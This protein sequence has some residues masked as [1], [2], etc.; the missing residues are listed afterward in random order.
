M[1]K[2]V[3]PEDFLSGPGQAVPAAGAAAVVPL[4]VGRVLASAVQSL[5]GA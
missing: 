2:P 1:P 3:V 5:T 4:Q